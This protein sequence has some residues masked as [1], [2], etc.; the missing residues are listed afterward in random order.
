LQI[1]YRNLEQASLKSKVELD[2]N[3]SALNS[4]IAKGR[5]LQATISEVEAAIKAEE[6]N[7]DIIIA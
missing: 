2:R 4:E 3:L 1:T 5:D 7:L 6:N